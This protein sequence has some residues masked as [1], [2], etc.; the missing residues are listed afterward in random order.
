MPEPSL[1]G[2]TKSN[3][4][5][6]DLWGKNQFNSSF[7]ASLACF[8]RENNHSAVYLSVD[9]NLNVVANEIPIDQLFN[10]NIPNEEITFDF[11]SKYDPYQK[12]AFD[13][14]RNID[15]VLKS[16]NEFLR[17]LEVKLTVI[18]DQTTYKKSEELWSSELVIRP[19]T[20]S[21]CALGIIDSCSS[22]LNE[23]K[24]LF[25]SVGS[26][27]QHWDNTT[28][29][30]VNQ[31]RIVSVLDTFQKRYNSFQKPFL[32]QPIWKTKGK[33][34]VLSKNAFDLFIWSDFALCRT[35]L[36][37]SF[38]NQ[39]GVNRFMRSSARFFRIMYEA[40]Q[41]KKVSI[42][43]IYA[44]MTFGHQTDKEFSLS[45]ANTIK[46]MQS[47]RRHKPILP[48]EILKHIILNGGEKMLSPER[49][50]DQSIYYTA[51]NLFN[52]DD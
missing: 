44:E 29:I 27:I 17:A 11:E 1:F 40:T 38:S 47:E 25:E 6:K 45:G 21:Y 22:V 24:P 35:F 13:D 7:P 43:R 32:M 14:I 2:I 49:R 30:S 23:L 37:K 10:T 3:R 5:G 48:P 4:K 36:D 50:F 18:P 51:A 46:Y 41:S 26:S 52:E 9:D 31:E 19:A 28:E 12:W 42:N 33:S 15:L 16:G 34:P 8:M 20:T 39:T